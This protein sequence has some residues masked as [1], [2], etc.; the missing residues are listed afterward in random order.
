MSE[1]TRVALLPWPWIILK[2]RGEVFYVGSFSRPGRR[3]Q[4]DGVK[5]KKNFL[6]S[7]F[8]K[9]K[10][11]GNAIPGQLNTLQTYCTE[12]NCIVWWDRV[13][14]KCCP[15]VIA[16]SIRWPWFQPELDTIFFLGEN[17]VKC[18]SR[19][20]LNVESLVSFIKHLLY[21]Q[22]VLAS[23]SELEF[24]CQ[25]NRWSNWAEPPEDPVLKILSGG[26]HTPNP[27]KVNSPLPRCLTLLTIPQFP[28]WRV[29]PVG[30]LSLVKV[31]K[32]TL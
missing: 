31:I 30:N 21:L 4:E 8:V 10:S 28:A 6:S 7:S 17:Q 22:Q 27:D 18:W 20:K 9:V 25:S 16:I 14:F 32:S 2:P 13:A 3:R 11:S 29:W 5:V 19:V 1:E 26:K 12:R 23:R 15:L 24:T